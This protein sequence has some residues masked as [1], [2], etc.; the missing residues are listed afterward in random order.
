MRKKLSKLSELIDFDYYAPDLF[1][2]IGGISVI[3]FF[4]LLLRTSWNAIPTETLN[5]YQLILSDSKTTSEEIRE[6]YNK[7]KNHPFEDEKTPIYKAIINHPNTPEDILLE[8]INNNECI[9][10]IS[11]RGISDNLMKQIKNTLDDE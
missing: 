1:L 10:E 7:V 9:D 4:A 8:M 2:I 11:K 3:I 5:K 6:I